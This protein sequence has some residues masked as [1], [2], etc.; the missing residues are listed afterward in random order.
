MTPAECLSS[1]YT[2]WILSSA[3]LSPAHGGLE[4]Q[5]IWGGFGKLCVLREGTLC[6]PPK[7]YFCCGI[8]WCRLIEAEIHKQIKRLRT[9]PVSSIV[10]RMFGYGTQNLRF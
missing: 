8:W 5:G 9:S 6:I 4:S 1:Y 2:H 3:E 7:L 10:H